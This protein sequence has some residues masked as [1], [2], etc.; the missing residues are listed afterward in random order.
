MLWAV[1]TESDWPFVSFAKALAK[2]LV[3]KQHMLDVLRPEL[4][5]Q[6]LGNC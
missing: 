5:A 1:N 6:P 4:W 2:R 3:V